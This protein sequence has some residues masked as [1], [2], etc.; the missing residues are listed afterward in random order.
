M[1]GETL[2]RIVHEGAPGACAVDMFPFRELVV[3]APLL[4]YYL[5]LFSQAC[6]IVV[7]WSRLSKAFEDHARVHSGHEERTVR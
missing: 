5:M 2:E 1:F 7:S 3:Y 6:A 4:W